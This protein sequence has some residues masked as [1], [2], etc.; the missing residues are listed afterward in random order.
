MKTWQEAT[1]NYK[2]LGEFIVEA[3]NPSS[4]L[5][6]YFQDLKTEAEKPENDR[7]RQGIVE[8]LKIVNAD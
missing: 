6:Y 4:P 3:H 5:S 7:I 8:L 1:D 2:E